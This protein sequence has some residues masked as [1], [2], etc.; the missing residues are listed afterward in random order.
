MGL[1]PIGLPKDGLQKRYL[2]E[3]QFRA[4]REVVTYA[5]S[6]GKRER[7]GFQI[8]KEDPLPDDEPRQMSEQ[9]KR[10]QQNEG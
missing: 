3:L 5:T 2:A 7:I 6:S 1:S 10:S 8:S 4:A 9:T